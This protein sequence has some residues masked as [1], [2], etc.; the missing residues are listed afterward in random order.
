MT[1]AL[2]SKK[3]VLSVGRILT[4]IRQPFSI[5]LRAVSSEEHIVVL[6]GVAKI[7]NYKDDDMTF[8]CGS[9]IVSF[10]GKNLQCES[11]QNGYIEI[12]G[13]IENINLR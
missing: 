10:L 9:S 1:G 4:A 3:K 11:F 12:R 2:I 5:E 6:G 7:M 8:K 13:K